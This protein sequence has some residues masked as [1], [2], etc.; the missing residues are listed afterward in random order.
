MIRHLN[1]FF[2][3]STATACYLLV[4]F[5]LVVSAAQVTLQWDASTPAPD[6]YNVYQ[7]VD[8]ANYDYTTPVNASGITGTT[9][10]LSGLAEGT[11]YYFVIRAYVGADMSGDSNEVT[12]TVPAADPDSDND[13]YNDSVDMFPND[14]SEWLDTDNDGVG[15]N[16]DTDDDGDGMPDA[17][18]DLYGLNPLDDADA[19]GD[20]D[21]DGV[22]NLNEYSNGTDP[23][24]VPGN[25]VPDQ[26]ILA[27]PANGALDVDLMPTLMTE[28]FSD[29]DG[30]AHNRTHYQIATSTDWA[31]DLV[32]EGQFELHLTSITLGDLILDAETT[33]YWRVRFYDEHNGA[34][35]WSAAATFTTMISS[36]AGLADDDG[37]GILNDQEVPPDEVNP[38]LNA[39]PDTYVVGTPDVTNPQLGVLL[40]TNAD[41]ISLRAVDADSVEVGSIANRPEVITG[42]ISFKLR[43]QP[44]VTMADV[45]IN[46]AEAAPEN[47]IWFKY[48]IDAGWVPYDNVTFSGD[49]KSI[50]LHL[51]DGGAGDDDGVQNGVIVDPSGLGYSS[52][53]E[54]GISETTAS[55]AEPGVGCFIAVSKSNGPVRNS[56]IQVL[57]LA[58]LVAIA[59]AVRLLCRR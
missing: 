20:L 49:R 6:G 31:S 9:Y 39:T 12:Y 43:L 38:A 45:T 27:A 7:R 29:R 26:P 4:A 21:G 46:F 28:A 58:G 44:G 17:W 25:T 1:N 37:D 18:E 5:P 42:L 35:Q 55:N 57:L 11:T 8:G 40:S 53:S 22:S 50:T 32:F 34:S 3:I 51:T 41:I 33:Y 52:D 47:G 13:G 54:Y 59:G 10:T 16:T 24:Q 19:A 36:D 14:S 2:R 23:S 30:D 56:H 48:D 15:N